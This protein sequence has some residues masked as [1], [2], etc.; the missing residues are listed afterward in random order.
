[1]ADAT[2]DSCRGLNTLLAVQDSSSLNFSSLQTTQ[3]LGPLNDSAKARGLHMHTTLAVRDDGVTMGVL[4]QIYWARSAEGHT[5]AQRRERPIEDKESCK[6]LDGIE[7][8]ENAWASLPAEQRPRLIH[9][10]DREG[11]IHEVLQRIS[12]SPHYGIIRSAQNR[13]VAGDINKAFAAVEAADVRGT[14][15]V[16]VPRAAY[17]PTPAMPQRQARLTVRCVPLT[18]TPNRSKHPRRQ[19]VT[20]TLLDVRES[21]PPAGVEP[22]HWRLWTNLPAVTMDDILEILRFYGFRWR[23]EDFHLILK[24]GCQ[25]EKLGLETA[26]RLIKAATLYAAVAARILG[27]RDLARVEPDAP[28]TVILND[29]EWQALW[30]RFA[31]EK[32]TAKTIFVGSAAWEAISAANATACPACER[33]G[34]ASATWPCWRLAFALAKR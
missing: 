13:S 20:W 31:K 32:L 17:Q 27:L 16:D 23:V 34:G 6:W 12:A 2:S 9:V 19:P 1:V 28:C 5:A 3:G 29:S 33:C 18:I 11:D 4:D 15:L 26:E 8:A 30:V 22:L 25:I 7:A 14:V 21:N 10:M 24:S